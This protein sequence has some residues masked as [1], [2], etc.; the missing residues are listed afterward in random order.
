[1]LAPPPLFKNRKE[2]ILVALLLISIIAI[3]LFFEYQKFNSIR[4]AKNYYTEAQ[5]INIY[6]G[7]GYKKGSNLLKLKSNDGLSFY[8][9]TYG[10]KPK[11]YDWLRVKLRLK[12]NTNFYD[13][14]KGFFAYGEVL[15]HIEDGFDAKAYLR[16]LIDK[17]HNGYKKIKTFYHAIFL[18]DPLD[19]SLRH[20]ISSL[21]VSHL[22]AISGFHLGILWMIIFG[23]LFIP[24]RYLQQK[25]FPWRYRNIDLGLIVLTLLAIF[26]LFVGAPPALVRSFIMLLIGW[27]IL[28]LGLEL[29]S[30]KFLAL[31]LLLILAFDPKLIASLGLLLS[32][33]GVFYIFLTI[34]WFKDKSPWFVTFIA[35]PV[36]IFL[37]M[38]PI[39][40][41]FFPNTTPWQL[42]SPILSVL[43][44][45]FYPIVA[46]LHFFG[47]GGVFDSSLLWLFNL[48]KHSINIVAM[49]KIVILTYIASSIA[50]IFSKKAY[51]ATLIYATLITTWYM[52]IYLFNS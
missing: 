4:L 25:Y 42:M 38:F 49:P 36:G 23:F 24:Y 26:T 3:R 27:V 5:V 51:Y 39:G 44:I 17:Q 8:L 1:M 34:K 33:T 45:P 6:K 47:L 35:I 19:S 10:E 43:F 16:E 20:K 9:Y 15:E 48:P 28:I 7:K 2:F 18:A 30:F 32:I 12:K 22:V 21:G 29:L 50:S 37:L 40:H 41:Y 14:L 52:L 11:R 46:L 31:A 13:Y